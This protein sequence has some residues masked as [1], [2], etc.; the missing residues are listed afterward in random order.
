[1]EGLQL[2]EELKSVW[3]ESGE[4]SVMTAGLRKTLLLFVDSWD[5]SPLVYTVE[6][7]NKGHVGTR[8]FVLYRQVSFIRRLQCTGIIRIGT[9]RF[10]LYREVSYIWSVHYRRFHCIYNMYMN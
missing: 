1:M 6:P 4:P 5:Y 10:V 7:P 8:S 9:S 2:K 3:E